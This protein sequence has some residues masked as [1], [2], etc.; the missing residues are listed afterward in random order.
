VWRD[1]GAAEELVDTKRKNGDTK[2]EE[3]GHTKEQE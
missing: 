1:N 2:E 3:Q